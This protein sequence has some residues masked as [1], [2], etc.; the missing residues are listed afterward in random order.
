[1]NGY[2]LSRLLPPA[3]EYDS[4]VFTAALV[5]ALVVAAVPLVLTLVRRLAPFAACP[6]PDR[7]SLPPAPV[8]PRLV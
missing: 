8:K 6:C 1:M 7:P 4:S 5:A 2:E 3:W